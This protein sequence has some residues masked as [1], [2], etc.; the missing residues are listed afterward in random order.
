MHVHYL[1]PSG[2]RVKSVKDDGVKDQGE[3]SFDDEVSVAVLPCDSGW[4]S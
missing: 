1:R 3:F 4:P 2:S